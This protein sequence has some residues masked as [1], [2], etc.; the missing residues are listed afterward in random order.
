MF[1]PFDPD[2]KYRRS[3]SVGVLCVQNAQHIKSMLTHRLDQMFEE[4]ENIEIDYSLNITSKTKKNGVFLLILGASIQRS[5][6]L[7]LHSLHT[8]HE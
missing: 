8:A 4:S 1:N 2:E 3:I 5:V 6:L 7:V